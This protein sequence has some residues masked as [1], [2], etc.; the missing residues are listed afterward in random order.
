[1]D[2]NSSAGL[3]ISIALFSA[4]FVILFLILVFVLVLSLG[5]L[6]LIGATA[7]SPPEPP[8][9]ARTAPPDQSQYTWQEIVAGLDN[10]LFVTHAGDGSG[11]LFAVEQTGF[12]LIV[13]NGA[14]NPRPF[15]DV[16]LLLSDDV[17][18]GGYSE[19]GLLGL[20]F[21][22]NYEQNG[23]L[24]ISHTDKQGHSVLAR[25]QTSSAN[26]NIADVESRAELL[27][28]EQPFADH[29]GGHIAFGPDGYLYF[30]VGD[31]GNPQLLNHNSQDPTA[32]LGKLLRLDVD[33]APYTIP[34]TNPFVDDPQFAP[35]IWAMGLR[36]PWRF[37]FDRAT[38]D[39]YIG[40]VGQWQWEEV[41][42][43]PASS[44]GGENYGWSAFEATHRYEEFAETETLHS[45]MTA[46]ILEYPHA[47]GCSVTGGY[48][49]RGNALP[50]LR[51]TYFHGD[52]CTGFIWT[53]YRD[54]AENWHRDTFE[55]SDY[56][57]SSF[58]ED[59]QGEIY[60]VDYKGAIYRLEAAD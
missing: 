15:L 30:G 57:I 48:V 27:T 45:E 42:F 31:G 41:N 34:T 26:P 38:G 13:E 10:P 19:R 51:G 14:L 8:I 43:Q 56:I 25:Y 20:A 52:Y 9:L 47:Q 40:D 21:H 2:D 28:V 12:I 18:Q 49:Y 6:T 60:L 1:M 32:L 37:S 39:L 23:Y 58:G 53:A 54:E 46:P 3:A 17:L 55:D 11:R 4:L 50:D 7:S 16:S 35:E 5:G 59:E 33:T 36:N 22:P 24:Y 44:P 29:N